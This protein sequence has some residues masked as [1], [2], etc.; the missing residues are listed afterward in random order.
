MDFIDYTNDPRAVLIHFNPNHDP[1]NGQFTKSTS[2]GSSKSSSLPFGQ[3]KYVNPDGTLTDAGIARLMA[4][5]QRNAQ[6]KKDDQVKG[7]G[8]DDAERKLDV[9]R[10]LA[11]PRRWVNE[12][13]SNYEK[14]IKQTADMAKS[15][16]EYEQKKLANQPKSRRKKLDLSNMTDAELNEKINRYTLEKRYQDIFNPEVPPEVSKGKQWLMN[17]LAIAGTTLSVAG[18][19]VAIAK[20]INDMRIAK[21]AAQSIKGVT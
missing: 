17:T 4:D 15:I 12:D 20:V 18:S 3:D 5:Y 21:V 8:S 14:S 13:L 2:G 19:A 9:M 1:K 6:K 7:E 16:Q 11:D 10:K